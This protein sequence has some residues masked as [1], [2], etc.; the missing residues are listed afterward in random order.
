V[1]AESRT[2]GLSGRWMLGLVEGLFCRRD[3]FLGDDVVDGL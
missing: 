1:V 3:V 2:G